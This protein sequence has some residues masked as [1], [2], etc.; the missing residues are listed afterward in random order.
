VLGWTI[1]WHDVPGITEGE[2]FMSSQTLEGWMKSA[3]KVSSV[4]SYTPTRLTG[5][6][7]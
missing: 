2:S 3:Y 5:G 7:T 1:H 4:Y 6:V